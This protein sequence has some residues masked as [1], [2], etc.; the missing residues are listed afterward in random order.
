MA[1]LQSSKIGIHETQ[2]FRW[3]TRGYKLVVKVKQGT[4][5]GTLHKARLMSKRQSGINETCILVVVSSY[6]DTSYCVIWRKHVKSGNY[7]CNIYQIKEKTG[8]SLCQCIGET[9]EFTSKIVTLM[10]MTLKQDAT[11]VRIYEGHL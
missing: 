9:L 11:K 1:L 2:A 6:K 5:G 7:F 3:R 4:E 10:D 8:Y